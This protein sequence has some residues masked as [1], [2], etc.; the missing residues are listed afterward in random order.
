MCCNAQDNDMQPTE[1]IACMVSMPNRWNTTLGLNVSRSWKLPPTSHLAFRLFGRQKRGLTT[2]WHPH[3]QSLLLTQG[4]VGVM[5]MLKDAE[6]QLQL[7]LN[8][9]HGRYDTA[10]SHRVLAPQGASLDLCP[11]AQG[12]Q[13]CAHGPGLQKQLASVM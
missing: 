4:T 3:Y 12:L 11:A 13:S 8:R 9:G 10:T 1:V 7:S 6:T 2:R 5:G